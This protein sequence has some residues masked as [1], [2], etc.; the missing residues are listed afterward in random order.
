[1]TKL[2]SFH[3]SNETA[4]DQQRTRTSVR[5]VTFVGSERDKNEK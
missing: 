4:A 2:S 3:P 5:V 1:M